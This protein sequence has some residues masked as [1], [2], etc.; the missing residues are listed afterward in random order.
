ME[1]QFKDYTLEDFLEDSDFS[2]WVQTG[3]PEKERYY[4]ELLEKFPEKET[5]FHKAQNLI[6]LFNDEKLI[7]DPVRKLQIWENINKEYHK[8]KRKKLLHSSWKY[9]A[10]IAI[11]LSIGAITFQSLKKHYAKDSFSSENWTALTE[12]Y[13]ILNQGEKIYLDSDRPEIE[14]RQN[15]E[16]VKINQQEIYQ[17]N[18]DSKEEMNELV[19]PYGKQS[20]IELTDGSEIWVNAGSKLVFPSRFDGKYRKVQLQGEAFFKVTK[21]NTKPFIVE[22]SNMK[23]NVL[24]TSFN[25]KAYSDEKYQESVLVEG[26]ISMEAGNSLFPKSVILKPDQRVTVNNTDA[27]I[28][29]T[30]VDTNN[31]TSWID[32]VF[33]FKEEPIPSVLRRVSRFYNLSI[34]WDHSVE[35]IKISGKLDLKDDY[36]RVLNTLS[37][38]S[39][40]DFATKQGM[41]YYHQNSMEMKKQR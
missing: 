35:E 33:S 18:S 12:A 17:Q 31:Y 4:R 39:D 22:T 2:A 11:I 7:T 9:A 30:T 37:L 29:V 16:S 32:G 6:K 25:V 19:V 3:D 20:K 24:G 13:I 1:K 26:S 36:Q 10:A 27:N 8:Q 15:G 28:T 38:I 34:K 21:D 23:I 14:Y 5:I 41:I 40:G